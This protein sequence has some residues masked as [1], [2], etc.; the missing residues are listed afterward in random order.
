MATASNLKFATHDF[1]GRPRKYFRVESSTRKGT[2]DAP[3]PVKV[4]EEIVIVDRSGSMW[5]TMEEVKSTL[6]KLFTLDEFANPNFRVSLI[7]YSSK[8]DVK[9]HF[10]RV[11]VADILKPSSEYL[12]EIRSIRATSMTC[13]SQA[14]ELAATL[15]TPGVTTG[16]VLHTDGCA[17]DPYPAAESRDIAKA[18]DKLRKP[19]VFCNTIGY[20]SWADTTMLLG[21]A[22]ALSGR[23]VRAGDIRE[24]YAA[25]HDTTKLLAGGMAPT[26]EIPIGK[27]NYVAAVSKSGRLIL[28]GTGSLAISSLAEGSDL[29]EYRYYE[30]TQAE[31]AALNAPVA[32]RDGS[33]EPVLAYARARAA[34]GQVTEAKFALVAS[35]QASLLNAHARALVPSQVEAMVASLD[36]AVL[37]GAVETPSAEYGLKVKGVSMLSTLDILSRYA[38]GGVEIDMPRFRAGYKSRGIRKIAGTRQPDGTIVPPKAEGRSV[39]SEDGFVPLD[40]ILLNRNTANVNL[41]VRGTQEIFKDGQK[42]TKIANVDVSAIPTFNNYTVIANGERN[43]DGIRVRIS[44][45]RAH[46]DLVDAGVVANTAYVPGEVQEIDF[47]PM[48]LTDYDQAYDAMTPPEFDRLVRLSVVSKM[49]SGMMEGASTDLTED[50]VKELAEYHLSAKLNFSPPSTNHYTDLQEA[51]S[52]GEVDSR[53]VYKIDFGSP[54]LTSVSNLSSA[55]EFLKRRF[56][57]TTAGVEEKTPKMPMRRG[58]TVFTVKALTGRTKLGYEDTI[59]FPY[60]EGFLGTGNAAPL[61]DLLVSVGV[62]P[63]FS[64]RFASKPGD[65]RDTLA[66]DALRKVDAAIEAIYARVRPLAFYIGATGL[67]PENLESPSLSPDD[68]VAKF[69]DA[70]LSKNEK[71]EGTFYILPNGTLL[72]IG[73]KTEYFSV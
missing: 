70:K 15:I 7:S 50:Q 10:H 21:I 60:Y 1:T 69:P 64:E 66:T 29:S 56:V 20:G 68:L 5:G 58:E 11:T 33:V 28:G 23:F 24:V 34:A 62:E 54:Q 46:A 2:Q 22:N 3:A 61:D 17:N 16:I 37:D 12:R 42:K 47:R 57:A 14:L 45:K 72:T 52:K 9:L 59:A 48:G 18:T 40:A 53:V 35:L 6:E 73:S 55:N 26:I 39:E 38:G 49:F 25:L 13:I 31:Y 30:V 51:I 19:G 71:E 27:A 44:N 8:G 36:H 43:V 63:K 41:R 4:S 67:L 65:N 32:G